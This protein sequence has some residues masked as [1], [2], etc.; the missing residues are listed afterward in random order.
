M[1]R[2][3]QDKVKL[4]REMSLLQQRARASAGVISFGPEKVIGLRFAPNVFATDEKVS[5]ALNTAAL[6]SQSDIHKVK[7]TADATHLLG[8]W[9]AFDGTGRG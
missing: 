6:M 8:R 7:S 3:R 5:Q 4:S 2:F 9:R 1:L